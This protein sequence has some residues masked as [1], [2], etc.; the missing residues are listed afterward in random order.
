[1]GND[2]LAILVILGLGGFVIW[3]L[4]KPAAPVVS[5][6]PPPPACG[7]SYAGVGVTCAGAEY[8]IDKIVDIHK[9]VWNYTFGQV[10]PESLRFGS[11]KICRAPNNKDVFPNDRD[12]CARR[13]NIHDCNACGMLYNLQTRKWP[14]TDE[15]KSETQVSG[16]PAPTIKMGGKPMGFR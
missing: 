14:W 10:L 1:M 7:G 6:E 15:L 12:E 8:A 11:T 16:Y 3:Y 5:R 4:T 9:D 2:G 13:Y